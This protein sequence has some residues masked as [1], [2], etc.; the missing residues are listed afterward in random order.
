[1]AR[2]A[3]KADEDASFPSPAQNRERSASGCRMPKLRRDREEAL[4]SLDESNHLRPARR[5]VAQRGFA[6]NGMPTWRR[7][8]A[9]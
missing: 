5:A 1:M 4:A 2:R 9:C 7:L 6:A 3:T 8:L